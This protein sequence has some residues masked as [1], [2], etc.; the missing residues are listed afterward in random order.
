MLRFPLPSLP[1]LVFALTLSLASPAA[2]VDPDPGIGDSDLPTS[3]QYLGT[4][5]AESV[6]TRLQYRLRNT[7]FREVEAPTRFRTQSILRYSKPLGDSGLVLR[8][9]APLKPRKLIKL[10]LQF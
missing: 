9:K 3:L 1:L 10:E 5:Q 2:A 8:V 4:N 7:Q 6:A